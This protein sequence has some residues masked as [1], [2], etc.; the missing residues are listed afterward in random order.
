MLATGEPILVALF[1]L[2]SAVTDLDHELIF[3]SGFDEKLNITKQWLWVLVLVFALV[4]II[5]KTNGL[6]ILALGTSEQSLKFDLLN[7]SILSFMLLVVACV[8]SS[9]VKLEIARN[10]IDKLKL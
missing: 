9:N 10:Q 4:Y 1:V 6:M 2:L 5:F 8:L 3:S 7:R